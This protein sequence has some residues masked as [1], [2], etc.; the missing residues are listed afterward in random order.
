MGNFAATVANDY[1]VEDGLEPVVFV[2]K[3]GPQPVT[4]QIPAASYHQPTA[5]ELMAGGAAY[6]ERVAA[7]WLL[8]RVVISAATPACPQ[9]MAGDAILR[10]GDS[11]VWEVVGPV[12]LDDFGIS[13][14]CNVT[15]AR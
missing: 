7:Q 11:T 8:P 15:L 4:V 2:S 1:L 12:V 3:S 5:Q 6:V 9:P 14:V 10:Q 13:Y